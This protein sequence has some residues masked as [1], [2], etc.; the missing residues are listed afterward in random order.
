MV[1]LLDGDLPFGGE[2]GLKLRHEGCGGHPRD[3][4]IKGLRVGRFVG[5]FYRALDGVRLWGESM[6][7][8][9]GEKIAERY[10]V[11]EAVARRV[12]SPVYVGSIMSA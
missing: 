4:S 9:G 7:F 1:V 5:R 6:S 3:P 12:A 10:I 8:P 2:V 11:E